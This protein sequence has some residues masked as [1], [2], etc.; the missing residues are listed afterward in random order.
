MAGDEETALTLL[1]TGRLGGLGD[2]G[3]G[4]R[5]SPDE[6]LEEHEGG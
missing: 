1:R 5:Q 3:E 4:E 2:A 6:A